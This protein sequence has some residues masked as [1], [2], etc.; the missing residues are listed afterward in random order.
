MVTTDCPPQ[1]LV[2]ADNRKG[3]ISNAVLNAPVDNTHQAKNRHKKEKSSVLYAAIYG[4]T[5]LLFFYP[6]VIKENDIY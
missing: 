6:C 4:T 2:V 1:I 3:L 5:F